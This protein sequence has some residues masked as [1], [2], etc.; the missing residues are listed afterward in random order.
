MRKTILERYSRTA[1]NEIVLDIAAGKIED[2][3]SDFDKYAP[4]V[5]K[6]LDQNLVDYIIDSVNEIGKEDFVIQF[7]FKAPADTNQTSRV[8]TSIHNYFL[9]LK[10]LELRELTSM[11]R[12]SLI[13]FTIGFVILSLSVLLNKE[14]SIQGDYISYIF[15]EGLNVAAWVALW[16]AIAIFLINWMP[17]RRKIAMYEKI[18]QATI[19]FND[20]TPCTD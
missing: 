3:F 13:L 1:E 6:D 11:T 20:K 19:L 15:S 8:K 9:Y 7:H 16:N 14:M 12:T 2:L 18:S 10:E 17:H 4:Y 5:K